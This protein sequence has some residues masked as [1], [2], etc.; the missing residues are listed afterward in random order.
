M[1]DSVMVEVE[2]GYDGMISVEGVDFVVVFY[3]EN[4]GCFV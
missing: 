1:I 4:A 2:S 3:F